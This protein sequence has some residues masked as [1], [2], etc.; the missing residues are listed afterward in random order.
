MAKVDNKIIYGKKYADQWKNLQVPLVM[1]Q[2]EIDIYRKFILK[3]L[4]S[5]K[6]ASPKALPKKALLLGATPELRDLLFELGFEVTLVDI[7]PEMVAAMDMLVKKSKNKERKIIGDWLRMHEDILAEE[8]FDL[9]LGDHIFNHLPFSEFE[10]M[11]KITSLLLKPEGMFLTNVIVKIEKDVNA[12]NVFAKLKNKLG[13]LSDMK[14][15]I[16]WIYAVVTNDPNIF[17]PTSKSADF[18]AFNK[19]LK[20][21][22]KEKKITDEEFNAFYLKETGETEMYFTFPTDDEFR[23]NAITFFEISE[24]DIAKGHEVFKHHRIYAM[25]LS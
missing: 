11:L 13:L 9:I 8:K 1:S 2:G 10:K 12:E 4:S 21:M 23:R 16:L 24:T 18:A 15:K 3:Y 22:H 14:N 25:R 6:S 5:S 7:N 17:N 20:K 19:A